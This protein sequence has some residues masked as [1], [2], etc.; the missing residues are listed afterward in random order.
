VTFDHERKSFLA[1]GLRGLCWE[2]TGEKKAWKLQTLKGYSGRTLA[3]KGSQ[4]VAGKIMKRRKTPIDPDSKDD[5]WFVSNDREKLYLWD[6]DRNKEP[7]RIAAGPQGI[8]DLSFYQPEFHLGDDGILIGVEYARHPKVWDVRRKKFLYEIP[9]KGAAKED[10]GWGEVGSTTLSADAKVLVVCWKAAVLLYEVASG[11]SFGRWDVADATGALSTDGRL[12]AIGT[13]KEITVWDVPSRR[14]L[15]RLPGHDN[16]VGHLAFSPD[17][18]VL[19][20]GSSDTTI[21]LWDLAQLDRGVPPPAK[22]LTPVE[23]KELWPDLASADIAKARQA[24][25]ALAAAG[26]QAIPLLCAGARPVP[27]W[28]AQRLGELIR[29]LDSETFSVRQQAH[30]E[31]ERLDELAEPA[32]RKALEDKPTAEVR[33]SIGKL[34]EG[35]T[36][37]TLQLRALRAVEVLE[38]IRTPSSRRALEEL[39]AGEPDAQM[40]VE[41]K[42][43]LVRLARRVVSGP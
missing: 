14:P 19:A 39:A 30:S 17:G 8:V 35:I 13:A 1:V 24:L 26:D 34:L 4:M 25:W 43:S 12:L 36:E 23:L 10:E 29:E 32:L 27:R 7:C 5:R 9:S 2:V 38:K 20:S 21:L 31:L 18:K 16:Y 33:R 6:R 22:P 3:V 11:R 37:R 41:A 40:T 42:A 15:K 28:S